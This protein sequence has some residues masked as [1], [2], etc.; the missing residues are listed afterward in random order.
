[1]STNEVEGTNMVPNTR[2]PTSI[3]QGQH[4]SGNF[5][6]PSPKEDAERIGKGGLMTVTT[7]QLDVTQVN[8][9]SVANLEKF[10][11]ELDTARLEGHSHVTSKR[12]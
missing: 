12:T 5:M 9:A 2:E 4:A 10:K 1:M 11:R 7:R 8:Y 6:I 3:D